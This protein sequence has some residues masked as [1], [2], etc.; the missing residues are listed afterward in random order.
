MS[1][2]SQSVDVTIIV[3]SFNTCD[4]TYQCLKSIYLQARAVTFEVLVV[5]NAS[6]DRSAQIVAEHFPQVK[7]IANTENRGFAAANNQAFAIARGRHV[8]LLNSDTIVLDSAIDKCVEY[9]DEHP[10]IGA[11]GPKVLWPAGDHQSSAFRFPSLLVL[12]FQSIG[13]PDHSW[14]NYDRYGARNWD[15]THDVDV[16]AGCFLMVR[17]EIIQTVGMLDEDFFLYGEEAEWCYRIKKANW[18]IVYWPGAQII[19]IKGGSSGKD[20]DPRAILVK[21][22]MGLVLLEKIR[23]TAVTWVGNLIMTFAL[24]PRIPVWSIRSFRAQRDGRSAEM[25][26]GHIRIIAFHLKCLV[27]PAWRRGTFWA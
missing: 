3:V 17:S 11:L 19:H 10:D 15:K 5:D 25:L 4:L 21:R 24:L 16:I 6:T 18:H 12:L 9:A 27:I 23:G 20:T 7:L 1:E 14:L 2:I 8:L 13:L 22:A 26:K